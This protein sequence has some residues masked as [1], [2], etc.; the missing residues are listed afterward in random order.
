MNKCKEFFENYEN[1]LQIDKWSQ[2]LD[3]YDRHFKKFIGKKPKILEIGCA[4]GGS[5]EMWNYY[6]D[7]KCTIYGIDI[8][9]KCLEIP[10]KL[11]ADNINISIGDQGNTNFWKDFLRDKSKF[12]IVIDDGGHTMKQQ[13]VTFEQVY[14]H[15][16]DD[17]VFVCE[18]LHTSYYRNFGGGLKRPGS[19]IEMSKKLID[20]L[21]CYYFNGDNK[22]RTTTDSIH[23]YDSII[24]IEKKFN[25]SRPERLVKK[26]ILN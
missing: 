18:D 21:H 22:F 5:L 11:K 2:Y 24:V 1:K 9:N 14:N 4:S 10:K 3:V 25:P 12:D 20:M 17:G 15:I 6:F 13:I 19:F 16:T 26:G 7:G 23:Y 8:N